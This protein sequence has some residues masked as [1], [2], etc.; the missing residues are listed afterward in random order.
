M[1]LKRGQITKK[2]VKDL[3]KQMDDFE[4]NIAER[5]LALKP[6][7]QEWIADEVS[8]LRTRI[9]EQ[10]YWMSLQS[11]AKHLSRTFTRMESGEITS[12]T[13]TG[14]FNIRRD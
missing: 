9:D 13:S 8:A 5:K 3:Q 14:G 7:F 1:G 12:L 11:L 6:E 4:S 10:D 2:Q